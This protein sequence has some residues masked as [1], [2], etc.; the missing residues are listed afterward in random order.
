V[1]LNLVLLGIYFVL[2]SSNG[3]GGFFGGGGGGD[4]GGGGGARMRMRQIRLHR[5]APL[6]LPASWPAM[7]ACLAWVGAADAQ[8]GDDGMQSRLVAVGS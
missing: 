1:A 8:E 4:G 7:S 6:P 3:G 2:E 5:L